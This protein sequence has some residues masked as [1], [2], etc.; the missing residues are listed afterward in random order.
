MINDLSV[1]D[2]EELLALAKVSVERADYEDALIKM[3]ILLNRD[4]FPV[5]IYALF[6]RTYTALELYSKAIES[7]NEFLY[8]YPEVIPERFH[9]GVVYRRMKNNE[10]ALSVWNEV[11]ELAPAFPPA[12]YNKA[13]LLLDWHDEDGAIEQLNYIIE[14]VDPEDDHVEMAS[15]M[16][17]SIS[18]SS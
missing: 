3:K 17:S 15:H 13:L 8:H 6:G 12:L 10:K 9:L 18:L 2:D 1:L 16:L 14:N 5:S 7:F 11:L 4:N